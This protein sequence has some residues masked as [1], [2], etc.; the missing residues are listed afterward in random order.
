MEQL[1]HSKGNHKKKWKTTYRRGEISA[2]DATNKGLL[3]KIYKLLIQLK[4][5]RNQVTQSKTGQKT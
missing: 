3:S 1:L 5:K 2:N 4:N